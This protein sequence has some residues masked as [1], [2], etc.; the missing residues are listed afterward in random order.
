MRKQA[1]KL[2]FVSIETWI[3]AETALF[4]GLPGLLT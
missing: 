1:Q 3:Q 2:P 4:H